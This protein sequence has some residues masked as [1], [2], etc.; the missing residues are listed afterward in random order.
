MRRISTLC[1]YFFTYEGGVV[2]FGGGLGVV[3]V[4]YERG[5]V[6]KDL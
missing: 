6:W 1:A 5:D 3:G 2:T 4:I